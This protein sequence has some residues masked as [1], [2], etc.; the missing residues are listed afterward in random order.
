MLEQQALVAQQTDEGVGDGG[1]V[2]A[3]VELVGEGV[4]GF[5]ALAEVGYVEDSFGVGEVEAGE[6]G[7]E[8]CFWTAEVGDAA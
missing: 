2:A 4:E 1:A 8:A 5:W 7:V 6:V 3:R